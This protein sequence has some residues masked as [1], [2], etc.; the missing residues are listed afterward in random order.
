[1]QAGTGAGGRSDG[2]GDAPG[3]GTGDRMARSVLRGSVAAPAAVSWIAIGLGLA[4]SWLLTHLIGGAQQVVPHWYYLPILFAAVRFGPVAAVV[5]ALVSGYIAGPLTYLDVAAATAQQTGR[6]LTRAGFFVGIGVTMSMLVRPSVPSIVAELRHRREEG[7]LARAIADGELFL[8]YQPIVELATGELHGVEALVRWQ[9]PARGELAPAAFL[10]VAE[11]SEVIGELGAF[12]LDAA[13][14]QAV[15]W[16][17]L[18]ATLGRPAPYVSVNMSARELASPSLIERVRDVLADTG[19]Y[20]SLICIEITESALVDDP[21]VTVALLAGL[22]TLGVRLAVDDFGTGY[23]S[24]SWV[25]RFP[26]DMLKIDRSFVSPIGRDTQLEALLGGVELFAR[27]LDLL[28]VAE[29]I[30]TAEQADK[31]TELGFAFGQGFHFAR[32]MV[33]AEIDAMLASDETVER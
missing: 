12:V 24:L 10:E 2:G 3:A 28:T 11:R 18:A 15:G 22:K 25:H 33:S 31:L 30:E 8:R 16:Q 19:T 5:V 4:V 27:S 32:P 20:P 6:W 29:G 23:S 7:A 1:M 26:I 9:H 14:R 13:C 17:Q 21:D